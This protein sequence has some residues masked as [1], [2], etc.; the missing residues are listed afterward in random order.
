MVPK[1]TI[2][3]NLIST[4]LKQDGTVKSKSINP[5]K[6]L[7]TVIQ[8]IKIIKNTSPDIVHAFTFKPNIYGGIM[9]RILGVKT[10]ITSITGMGAFF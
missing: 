2:Q 1:E 8:Y 3:M 7:R 9:A 5:I 4:A 10:V 6:E